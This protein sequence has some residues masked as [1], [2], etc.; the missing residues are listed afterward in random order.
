MGLT[1]PT[2]A[3]QQHIFCLLQPGGV[4]G[5]V[6]QVLPVMRLQMPVIKVIETLLPWEASI[7]QKPLLACDLEVFQL[8]LTE[9]VEKLGGAPVFSLCLRR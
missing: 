8:L 3:K 4:A 7:S 6:L 5:Q 9:G 1:D 2:G